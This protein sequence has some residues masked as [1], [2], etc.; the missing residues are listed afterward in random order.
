MADK[1]LGGKCTNHFKWD[2]TT[3][4]ESKGKIIGQQVLSVENGIPK[5]EVSI[6]GDRNIHW[7]SRSNGNLD[8]LG[9][10][11]DQMTPHT[12]KDKEE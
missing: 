2:F 9:M 4:Y 6:S 3:L 12:V 8:L 1:M 7:E 11:K 5:Q 10:Y